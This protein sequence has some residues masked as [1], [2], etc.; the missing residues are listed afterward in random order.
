M[1]GRIPHVDVGKFDCRYL[2]RVRGFLVALVLV[3]SSSAF[4]RS[5][6]IGPGVG[7]GVFIPAGF[8]IA[9]GSEEREDVLARN[10][11]DLTKMG[12]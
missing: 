2:T 7:S 3:T 4:L 1:S 6:A 9:G 11:N 5:C 10:K 8:T 12:K